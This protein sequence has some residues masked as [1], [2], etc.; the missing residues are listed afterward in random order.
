MITNLHHVA[1][2]TSN[3]E[4]AI[5]FY[6]NL[7]GCQS[8]RIAEV[9][10]PG[11]KLK[12]AMLPIGPTGDTY[13]QLIEPS[14]GPGMAE[15]ERGGEGTLFEVGFQVDD[16]ADLHGQMDAREIRP[17]DLAGDSIEDKFIESKFGNRYFFL[18]KDKTRGTRLEFVQVINK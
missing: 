13:L 8:P 11:V 14:E 5:Q 10:R 9:D 15:L 16:I 3:I 4:D 2:L 18:P 1:I 12:S 17:Q 6:T 7:L